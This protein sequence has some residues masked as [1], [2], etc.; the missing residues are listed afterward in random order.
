[1]KTW[2]VFRS[3]NRDGGRTEHVG[4]VEADTSTGALGMAE[5]QMECPASCY[6]WVI[7]E[8]VPSH[9][10]VI[11]GP[12]VH[13]AEPAPRWATATKTDLRT[14]DNLVVYDLDPQASELWVVAGPDGVDPATIDPD[15]LPAG[16][17][18]VDDEEWEELVRVD[19]AGR[20]TRCPPTPV[21]HDHAP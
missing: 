21:R 8:A 16:C 9:S 18:W 4:T 12:A 15:A 11:A 2:D 10:S 6:L 19:G 3:E 1:M 14:T 7:E 13:A 20:R 5:G 17:R